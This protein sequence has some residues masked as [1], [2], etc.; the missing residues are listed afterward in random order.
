M[1]LKGIVILLSVASTVG[2]VSAAS[3]TTPPRKTG[4]FLGIFTGSPKRADGDV[5][6]APATATAAD[7]KKRNVFREGAKT[8][9]RAL[10]VVRAHVDTPPSA[11]STASD[12]GSAHS[13]D[14]GD[15]SSGLDDSTASVGAPASA[16]ATA[17]GDA[18]V[19]TSATAQVKDSVVEPAPAPTQAKAS[20]RLEGDA[21]EHVAPSAA[22]VDAPSHKRTLTAEQVDSIRVGRNY[23]KKG[24]DLRPRATAQKLAES[25]EWLRMRREEKARRHSS[26]S[27]CA[28]PLVAAEAAEEAK[29]ENAV[30]AATKEALRKLAQE[31][32]S[33]AD[34]VALS[35]LKAM[36]YKQKGKDSEEALK[37]IASF[38]E[39]GR[40]T[41]GILVERLAI[42]RTAQIVK[43]ATLKV[44]RAQ[45][46]KEA[47]KAAQL[48]AKDAR[49]KRHDEIF[50]AL[51]K[52]QQ[53]KSAAAKEAYKEVLKA[54]AEEQALYEKLVLDKLDVAD[55]ALLVEKATLPSKDNDEALAEMG[56]SFDALFE[57]GE[58]LGKDGKEATIAPQAWYKEFGYNIVNQPGLALATAGSMLGLGFFVDTLRQFKVLRAKGIVAPTFST[59][60]RA[61]LAQFDKKKAATYVKI[62]A[63][64]LPL[65]G[66]G[67]EIARRI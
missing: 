57:Q 27:E 51:S 23:L 44:D 8:L 20:G 58:N 61:Q 30:L 13:A 19:D 31:H 38:I 29:D 25:H 65:I 28:T 59:F 62:G 63:L 52:E 33:P 48:A 37:V 24:T 60:F 11:R 43:R 16:P 39:A 22:A 3:N 7:V 50:A 67:L 53:E 14:H 54:A 42:E 17:S 9:G 36:I 18:T 10:G 66:C 26:V 4:S 21:T 55:R 15:G 2:S 49:A 12:G 64:A 1:L 40:E 56:A 46:A 41:P 6:P 45:A 47:Q 35:E 32:L 34:R 5:T